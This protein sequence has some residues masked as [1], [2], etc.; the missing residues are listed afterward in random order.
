MC[1]ECGEWSETD[2]EI[3]T[4]HQGTGGGRL[5]ISAP[6]IER[7]QEQA[8]NYTNADQYNIGCRKF[9]INTAGTCVEEKGC[10]LARCGECIGRKA[11]SKEEG[12]RDGPWVERE[13]QEEWEEEFMVG[14]MESRGRASN[15]EVMQ[16]EVPDEDDEIFGVN[17][18]GYPTAKQPH[19]FHQELDMKAMDQEVED[20]FKECRVQ[21]G[22]GA[23]SGE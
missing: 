18:I 11:L 5:K 14:V 19:N 12:E 16:V 9:F 2:E 23:A 8:Q 21:V 17:A 7:P 4:R 1:E 15:S 10:G 6:E 20:W 13:V 3:S 22:E